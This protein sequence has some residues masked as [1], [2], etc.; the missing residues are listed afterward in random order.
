MTAQRPDSRRPRRG[1]SPILAGV[2]LAAC[3][4]ASLVGAEESSLNLVASQSEIDRLGPDVLSE[5]AAFQVDEATLIRVEITSTL[6]A[7]TT[8]VVG[9]AGQ[10]VDPSTVGSFGG[11]F[12]IF[13]GAAPDSFLL[14]P[15]TPGTHYVY[16]FPSL[17]VG[18]Y[19]VH[20]STGSAPAEHVPVITEI[21]TDSPVV[22]S[23]V[24][25][26]S[27]FPVNFPIVLV[28]ALFEGASPVPGA[29]VTVA[30]KPPTTAEFALSLLDDG[31]GPDG[32]AGDGLYSG[33][34]TA[35]EVGAY[36]ALAQISGTNSHGTPFSRVSG[37]GISV[38]PAR[39]SLTG[40]LT[41]QGADDN[42]N[43]L[44]DRIVVTA[45]AD[46]TVAGDFSLRVTLRTP[47]GAALQGQGVATLATGLQTISAAVGAAEVLA[48]GESGPYVIESVELVWVG[49]GGVE[50]G[51]WITEGTQATQAY[52]LSQLERPPIELTGVNTD[53]AVDSDMDGDFDALEV[54]AG[55]RVAVAGT[56]QFAVRLSDPCG[57]QIEFIAGQQSFPSGADPEVLVLTFVGS[58]IGSHGVNGPYVVR[59]LLVSGTGGA[60]VASTVA[61]SQAYTA[62]QFDAFAGV[63]DCDGDGTAD[64][65]QILAGQG[66]DCNA[67]FHPDVC[68]LAAG[69]STDCDE[70]LIPDECQADCNVNAIPD[71]CEVTRSYYDL[72]DGSHEQSIGAGEGDMIW[73]NQYFVLAGAETID[74]LAVAWGSA[75]PDGTPTTLI[76]YDDPNNDGD[77]IDAVILAA[78]TANS[79]NSDTDILTTVP[80]PPTVAGSAGDSFFVA[81]YITYPSGGF[82]GSQ[83]GTPPSLE[84]SWVAVGGAGTIDINNLGLNPPFV[85]DLAGYPGNWLLRAQAQGSP[86]DCNTNSVPDDCDITSGTSTDINSNDT[87]DECEAEQA[88][89]AVPDGD[90]IPGTPLLVGKAADGRLDLQWGGSCLGSDADYAI[91]EGMLGDFTSHVWRVCSTTGATAT[92][93]S[94]STGSHYY[95]IVPRSLSREGSYGL[96]GDGAERPSATSPCLPQSIG[97]CARAPAV[98]SP[99]RRPVPGLPIRA[100]PR[101]P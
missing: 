23:L 71:S 92:E 68:D 50:P 36:N 30:V 77:P 16:A 44:F 72:D 97:G 39:A 57:E 20:V 99:G 79:S 29:T 94:P 19:T 81:A 75:I 22:T 47:L 31:T 26:E 66:L 48:V 35:T 37:T 45:E 17:G 98:A 58:S 95:L 41:D 56:Y 18:T 64:L 14:A 51:D 59:D 24:A 70:D 89:G 25:P 49:S 12:L 80:I 10:V 33:A 27:L 9:P 60:L 6:A 85:I 93:L 1:W 52:L 2:V 3:A 96:D 8:S 65:C 21:M 13:D 84:R 32:M 67:N 88:A 91:Y 43:T 5:T 74:A 28:A 54:R 82:P 7:L 86:L 4:V 62:S 38:V 63:P 61:S 55:I 73:L 87:P 15:T 101:V 76:L 83:D 78:V 40:I 69:T 34:F 90:A 100:K 53:L 42:G 11:E 46:V